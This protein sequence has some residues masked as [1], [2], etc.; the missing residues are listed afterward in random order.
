[1]K[2]SKI[3]TSLI[4]CSCV[5]ATSVFAAASSVEADASLNQDGTLLTISG[6]SSNANVLLEIFNPNKTV[7]D[8]ASE[9]TFL[10]TDNITVNSEDNRFNIT[11]DISGRSE[12]KYHVYCDDGAEPVDT[13]WYISEESSNSIVSSLCSQSDAVALKSALYDE[14]PV[15]GISLEPVSKAE[16]LGF[17]ISLDDAGKTFVATFI[18]NSVNNGTTSKVFK[19]VGV[20]AD[21]LNKIKT[22]NTGNILDSSFNFRTPIWFETD[23]LLQKTTIAKIQEIYD[24][25]L[26][27]KGRELVI[28]QLKVKDVTS[29]ED[30]EKLFLQE[31]CVAALNNAKTQGHGHI[32]GVL[33][34]ANEIMPMNVPTYFALD[35]NGRTKVAGKLWAANITSYSTLLSSMDTYAKQENIPPKKDDVVKKNPPRSPGVSAAPGVGAPVVQPPV[36]VDRFNDIKNHTWAQSA[37]ENLYDKGIVNGMGDGSF[38][39]DKTVSREEFLTMLLRAIGVELTDKESTFADVPNDAWYTSY[40][41]TAVEKGIMIG[42]SDGTAGIGASIT[43]EDCCVFIA[44]AMGYTADTNE[45]AFVDGDSISEYA[46]ESVNAVFAQG[47]IKGDENKNFNPKSF[48][49]RAQAAVMIDGMLNN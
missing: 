37:I 32:D 30:F 9:A 8:A 28:N 43:R 22:G 27:D 26:S 19:S 39:P 44:R 1:M 25:V 23:D 11:Y 5:S 48:C 46:V 34:K 29:L 24:D 16:I 2:L 10:L 13:F 6:T 18:K 35:T 49:T 47:I 4:L 3:I 42:L 45:N 12:G 36:K 21:I 15:E 14:A 7:S 31:N 33:T 38:A 41:M 40:I 17:D 20:L